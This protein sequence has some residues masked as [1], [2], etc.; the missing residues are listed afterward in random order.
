MRGRRGCQD[1]RHL[2]AYI[3]WCGDE[4]CDCYQPIIQFHGPGC[5]GLSESH[6][7]VGPYLWEGRFVT[8]GEFAAA[9]LE[10]IITLRAMGEHWPNALESTIPLVAGSWLSRWLS[11][12]SLSPE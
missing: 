12:T 5:S 10:M 4:Y 8:D 7:V 3:W 1:E 11:T 9:E 6:R 2:V